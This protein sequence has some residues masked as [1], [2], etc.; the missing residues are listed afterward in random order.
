MIDGKKW[1]DRKREFVQ[2]GILVQDSRNRPNGLVEKSGLVG[3]S[4]IVERQTLVRKLRFVKKL[5]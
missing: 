5:Y 1:I 3:K 4:V 2:K